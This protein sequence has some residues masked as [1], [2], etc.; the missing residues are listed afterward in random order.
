MATATLPPPSVEEDPKTPGRLRRSLRKVGSAVVD[1]DLRD[2]GRAVRN[3]VVIT[4]VA[5]KGV[6]EWTKGAVTRDHSYDQLDTAFELAQSFDA[7]DN[8]P[9]A[10]AARDA[11]DQL[12]QQ[13]VKYQPSD[14]LVKIIDRHMKANRQ[15]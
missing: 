12:L 10:L 3:G 14:K 5:A 8:G 15:G 1:T 13:A 9:A 11:Y 2:V 4:G 7:D 6:G